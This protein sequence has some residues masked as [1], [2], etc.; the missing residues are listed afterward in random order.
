MNASD[1]TKSFKPPQALAPSPQ[2]YDELVSD[3]MDNLAKATV[4][5]LLPINSGSVV[6]DAGCGTGAG[7]A[8]V[9]QS[10]R[11][12]A[13]SHI[14]FKGVDVHEGALEMYK[15]K[16]TENKWPVEAIKADAGKLDTITDAT[17]TH[18]L[19]TALLFVLPN[20]GVAAIQE[21]HRTLKIG[22]TA[23]FNS[24]A[25]TP[26]ME[27]LRAASARTRPEG[28]PEIR[29]GMDKWEDAEF[30][31]ATIEKG[32]FASENI[33]LIKRDVYVTAS[34]I[35]RYATMLW[36]FI[37][38]TTTAGWLESDAEKW[39]EAVEIV[40]AEVRKTDGFKELEDGKFLLKFVANIAIATK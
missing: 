28:T 14:K 20:D 33:E 4:A 18:A 21:I 35:D 30:L 26:N 10:I 13:V 5:E 19:G 37:G 29:G 31:K 38:G 11:L 1:S 25:H 34:A 2:L 24:W 27:P 7:T 6:L 23:A 12:D 17:F 15:K 32:G 36:S 9:V 3:G 8:A 16:A 39:D 22:G 40:K